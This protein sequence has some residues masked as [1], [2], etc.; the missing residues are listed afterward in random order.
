[1][2]NYKLKKKKLIFFFFFFFFFYKKFKK[3]INFKFYSII[4]IFLLIFSLIVFY[5]TYLINKIDF[6]YQ[7]FEKKS[8]NLKNCFV[9]VS[10]NE[11]VMGSFLLGYTLYKNENN[12]IPRILLVTKELNKIFL[13]LLSI[14]WEI[15]IIEPIYPFQ[16]ARKSW[17]KVHIWKLIEYDKIIYLDSD[18]ITLKSIEILF[19]Y[20]ELSCVSDPNPIQFCNTGVL[21][22]KPDLNTYNRF[23]KFIKKKE[24]LMN[25]GDQCFIN[26]FFKNFYSLPVEFNSL[27]SSSNEFFNYFLNNKIYI[28]HF[29]GI[30]PWIE[31]KNINKIWW[32]YWDEACFLNNCTIFFNFNY[33]KII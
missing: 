24:I 9:S 16:N 23:F 20:E 5:C 8:T 33:S 1:M 25:I 29:I 27:I 17:I 3:K 22:I 2:K 12:K 31:K 21:V 4:D 32:K 26:S 15:K 18:I 11:F 13:P 19:N 6:K 28:L 14:F 10:S 7:K 30:K